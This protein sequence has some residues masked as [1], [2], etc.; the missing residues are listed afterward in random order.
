M[1]YY[2][3]LKVPKVYVILFY[4][5]K[6]MQAVYFIINRQIVALQLY[7]LDYFNLLYFYMWQMIINF[8]FCHDVQI[9]R[10]YLIKKIILTNNLY[11][12]N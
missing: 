1:S 9:W 3:D 6:N 8:E 2:Y 5:K 11:F 10:V 12:I 7:L 4:I